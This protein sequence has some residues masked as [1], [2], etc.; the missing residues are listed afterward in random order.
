MLTLSPGAGL[1]KRQV[2]LCC[3]SVQIFP[4]LKGFLPHQE[5]KSGPS[6]GLRHPVRSAHRPPH[7]TAQISSLR[8]HFSHSALATPASL[9]FLEFSIFTPMSGPL[10]LLFSL[11]KTF[12]HQPSLA[13]FLTS[14]RVLLKRPSRQGLPAHPIFNG[15]PYPALTSPLPCLILSTTPTTEYA[16]E[17]NPRGNGTGWNARQMESLDPER[18]SGLYSSETVGTKMQ[19]KR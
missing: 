1:L 14:C 3:S 19:V 6:A 4:F 18:K 15:S 10:H 13:W 8:T 9:L 5:Q 12:F 11:V 2:R 16:M 7:L 17:R